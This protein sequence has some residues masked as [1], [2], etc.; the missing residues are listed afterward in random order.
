MTL[1]EAKRRL[2]N[3]E[4]EITSN[5]YLHRDHLISEENV[6][7]NSSVRHLVLTQSYSLTH[8]MTLS[9][10]YSQGM[11]MYSIVSLHLSRLLWLMK[12]PGEN[13]NKCHL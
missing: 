3:I 6:I 1:T 7:Q 9:C 13:H 4:K 5:S 12:L 11:D 2:L 8:N 10:I